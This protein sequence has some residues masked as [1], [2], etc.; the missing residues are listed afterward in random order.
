MTIGVLDWQPFSY[1]RSTPPFLEH[2][3]VVL[4]EV[5][6]K[7][8]TYQ[9]MLSKYEISNDINQKRSEVDS[10]RDS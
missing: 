9:L 5:K 4:G 8:Y 3:G 10:V 7:I 6:A 2:E 1:S